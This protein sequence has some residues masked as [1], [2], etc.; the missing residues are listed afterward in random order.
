MLLRIHASMCLSFALFVTGVMAA[1]Y[2]MSSFK[3]TTVRNGNKLQYID[4]YKLLCPVIIFYYTA[5][6]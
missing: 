5:A 2:F 3:T 6:N 1:S 4:G